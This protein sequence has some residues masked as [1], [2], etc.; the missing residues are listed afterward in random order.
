M[1]TAYRYSSKKIDDLV[2]AFTNIGPD[3]LES[4]TEIVSHSISLLI[5]Y[6]LF[7][8]IGMDF[9]KDLDVKAIHLFNLDGIYIPLSS[10]LFAAY[11]SLKDFET[12]SRDVVSVQY[13]PE[14]IAYEK[15]SKD[16]PLTREKWV[17]AVTKKQKQDSI[18]VHFFKNFPQYVAQRIK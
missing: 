5:G 12:L 7:D 10:F 1:L 16:D 8:D 4:G 18:S 17:R 2:F 3:T 11:D 9:S 6:F 13:S 15:S 14:D